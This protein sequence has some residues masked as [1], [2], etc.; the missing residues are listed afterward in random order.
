MLTTF[1]A[2]Q[3]PILLATTQ[4]SIQKERDFRDAIIALA[5][6]LEN[7]SMR[8][9]VHDDLKY[10]LSRTVEKAWEERV[11]KPFIWA[12]KYES[13]P[14]EARELESSISIMSL[15][16]VLASKKKLDRSK[17]TGPIVDAMRAVINEAH[18]LAEAM[19][20]LKAS[21]VKGRAAP[22][23]EKA[24]AMENPDK[25]VRTCACCS[26]GI[27]L[28][29]EHMAHHGYTRPGS[30]NQTS[31]CVGINFPPLEVS[32]A[33]LQFILELETKQLERNQ[34]A[35]DNR[36][37]IAKL[38]KRSGREYVEILRDDNDPAWRREFNFY[39]SNIESEIRYGTALVGD[40]KKRL[41]SWVQTEPE[42]LSSVKKSRAPKP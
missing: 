39:I 13:L 17:A 30:G 33:G 9:V 2:D 16:D 21:L 5:D 7:K 36:D 29:G 26:R 32:S 8:K 38:S 19:A 20:G 1:S 27:A 11:S 22:D 6:G 28:A 34:K 24:A 41:E 40:L 12:G 31:S 4:E 15:H 37:K 25:I 23:P 3:F 42:G 10:T 35:Y 18:P 14:A